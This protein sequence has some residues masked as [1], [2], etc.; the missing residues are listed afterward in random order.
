MAMRSMETSWSRQRL[1]VIGRPPPPPRRGADRPHANEAAAEARRQRDGR[2]W[3]A[4]TAK[5]FSVSATSTTAGL[6]VCVQGRAPDR[7]AVRG[8]DS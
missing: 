8:A 3:H 2:R 7:R 6:G 4:A 1:G 5:T